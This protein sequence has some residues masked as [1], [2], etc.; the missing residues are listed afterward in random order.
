MK[1]GT[2]YIIDFD[3]TFVKVEALDLLA[4]IA[5]KKDPERIVKLEKIKSL[6]GQ[7]MEGRITF[8][9][10]LK[11]RIALIECGKPEIE[12]LV[13]R[14]KKEVS[15]SI[16]NN[17]EFFRLNSENVIIISG[18][19]KEY[20]VPVA[21]KFGIKP[22]NV[23]ANTF[24]FDKKGRV[25]GYD[26][27]NSL[28]K[29]NG[30]VKQLKALKLKGKL[31]VI[32][33]GHTD[34]EL[35]E[36]GLIDKFYA[37]TENI[38]RESVVKKADHITPSFDEFLYVSRLPMNISYPKNRIKV[39]LLENIHKDAAAIFKAEG[40][41]VESIAGSIE[42]NQ[43][44]ER[45]KDVS[46]LG[47]RSKTVVS[48]KVLSKA[49]K[50]IAVGA[51]CVGTNQIDLDACSRRGIIAFNAPFS[52]TRS[53]VELVI[54]EMILLMRGIINKSNSLHKGVWD[55]S[56]KDSFEIRGKK[57]GIIGYGKIGSQLSVLAEDMG[58]E[59]YYYDVLE[60][61]AL[62]NARKC[63]TM[64]ELLK[65]CDVVTVHV[66]GSAQNKDLIGEKE[67]RIMKEGAIFMNLSRGSV[68]DIDALS[69][70]IRQG[71]LKGA[72]VDVFPYEPVNN[73]E[74]FVSPL[75]GLK[76][77]I[78]TPH[79]GGSTDEAQKDIAN[80]VPSKIIDFVNSGSSY[81]SVN[82]PNIQLPSF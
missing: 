2:Y 42:E 17:A 12:L 56:S 32:G 54:G 70:N 76:N 67:F 80:F 82:F 21:A 20:I 81:Y 14:L 6:T 16:L 37:F 53:V 46:I 47:I 4:E 10:S 61:L 39:L 51:F 41:K 73:E 30:K 8:A 5:L 9:E 11:R 75:Q 62:G 52:N 34:Y 27:R 22:E 3:S 60:K 40:Y 65:K 28:C 66:D 48:G 55:K 77:V 79:I 7:A 57:L 36:S 23:Y 49:R 63:H 19:F 33:D 31:I 68:V 29:S 24:R 71:K 35:K 58:M 50:L 78:L 38:E 1:T 45:I 26:T 59:V 18:G 69:R 13:K 43:L 74:A 64:K 15:R 72:S 25:S 44:T